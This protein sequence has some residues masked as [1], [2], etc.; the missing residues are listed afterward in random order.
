MHYPEHSTILNNDQ[1]INIAISNSLRTKLGA[2]V[3]YI[4]K[5][6]LKNSTSGVRKYI[7]AKVTHI[8]KTLPGNDPLW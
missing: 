7:R 3:G 4:Y 8:L 6:Q 5:V 1:I 2:N